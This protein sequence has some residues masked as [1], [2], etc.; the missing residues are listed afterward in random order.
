MEIKEIKKII[1]GRENN[2]LDFKKT[3][4]DI[5]DKKSKTDF[6]K[7]IL[8]FSNTTI[9]DAGYIICGIKEFPNG[10]K[11]FVGIADNI[12]IDD[13]PWI[14]IM[15][16]YCSHS[17]DFKI[18]K[19]YLEEYN[20]NIVVIK[21]EQNQKRPI[22]CKKT[23]G[24]KLQKGVIYFRDGSVNS[25]AEDLVSIEKIISKSNNERNIIS[26]DPTYNRYSKFPTQPYYEFVGRDDE[27]NDIYKQLIN[28]HKNYLLSLIGEGGIGKTSIAYHIAERLQS[29]IEK[30]DSEFD[31]VIWISAKD[32]RIYFD[33]RKEL[34]REF[35]GLEDLY[36]KILSVFY[37]SIFITKMAFNEKEEYI[38]EALSGSKFFFV[39]DN[40]EV[41]NDQDLKGI[42]E[43]INNAPTGHKFLITSRHD[44]RVQ[45]LVNIKPFDEKISRLYTKSVITKISQENSETLIKEIL[46]NYSEFYKLTNGNPLYINFFISQII[47][48]KSINDIIKR[49]NLESEKPLKTYCFD[50]TLNSLTSDELIT[51]YSLAVTKNNSLNIYEIQ[52]LTKQIKSQLEINLE[53]LD[54]YSMLYSEYKNGTKLYSLN[55]LLHIYLN[56]DKKIPAGEYSRLLNKSR[57]ISTF[58]KDIEEGFVINFGLNN[59]NNTNEKM[60][61]NLV[62]NYFNEQDSV[63][64]NVIFEE[65]K[66][67]Y[68]GNYLIPFYKIFNEIL[69]KKYD[70]YS[71]ITK[72]NSEF[73]DLLIYHSD[74]ESIEYITFWKC[75]LYIMI[76]SYDNVITECDSLI[77]S[78]SDCSYLIYNIKA[79]ALNLQALIEY[80]YQRYNTHN[81]LR[82]E[83]HSIFISYYKE[84]TKEKYYL[85]LKKFFSYCYKENARHIKEEIQNVEDLKPYTLDCPLFS[86]KWIFNTSVKC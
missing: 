71:I 43:F 46:N 37:D 39:L 80:E 25:I 81:N 62:L 14:Q 48:G 55:N 15:Q 12:N 45:G 84:F 53:R 16:S 17:I 28:H 31:D 57:E 36:N 30:G 51:L 59:V 8:A 22:I 74:Q 21:I 86:K 82:E 68:P 24:D 73:N 1:K 56:E 58:D 19:I 4:Y 69:D 85:F 10:H 41:F 65:A 40:L 47:K 7:D 70:E 34:E 66:L 18:E 23:D 63:K 44:L 60:S 72:I 77:K 26:T 78:T 83:A 33:E 29:D 38:S 13:A 5:T 2:L 32:Q 79:V 20:I 11:D 76:H 49:R 6:V 42:H 27:I 64:N 54:S 35:Y 75:V 61:Y 52:Y 67:L 9:H 3:F 50:S